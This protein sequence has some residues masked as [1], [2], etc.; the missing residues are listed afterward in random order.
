MSDIYLIAKYY[1][2][3]LKD[4]QDFFLYH[5]GTISKKKTS[6]KSDVIFWRY[7]GVCCPGKLDYVN[8]VRTQMKGITRIFHST[9]H[10]ED[11]EE[12]LVK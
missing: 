6:S 10:Y 2:C 5:E 4:L 9:D 7:Y 3:K 11:S 8:H 12:N 1:F